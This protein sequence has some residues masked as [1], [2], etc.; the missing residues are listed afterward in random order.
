MIT[1]ENAFR[2]L[3]FSFFLS[4]SI[5]WV[6]RRRGKKRACAGLAPVL[7]FSEFESEFS[8]RA[9]PRLCRADSGRERGPFGPAG[10]HQEVLSWLLFRSTFLECAASHLRRETRRPAKKKNRREIKEEKGDALSIPLFWVPAAA[11]S[12]PSVAALG[13]LVHFQIA[14]Q[15]E[16]QKKRRKQSLL[17]SVSF[18]F[19]SSLH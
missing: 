12:H 5:R 17:H 1:H 6:Q 3:F 18:R 8:L 13:L 2:L 11:P 15:P 9:L 16:A 19:F 14:F 10:A 7:N 4:P